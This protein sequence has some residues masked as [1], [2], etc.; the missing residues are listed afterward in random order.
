MAA[1]YFGGSIQQ[2]KR[3]HEKQPVAPA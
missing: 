1:L 2:S 3:Q